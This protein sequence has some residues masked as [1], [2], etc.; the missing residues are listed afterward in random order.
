MWETVIKNVFKSGFKSTSKF[1]ENGN[2]AFA[3]PEKDD[4]S[5][6][7]NSIAANAG[8]DLKSFNLPG[9]E[10]FSSRDAGA[11]PVG[12]PMFKVYRNPSEVKYLPAGYWPEPETAWT[13]PVHYAKDHLKNR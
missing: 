7:G 2:I 10:E 1:L 6:T 9:M 11:I 5:I 8:I 12:K 3:A 4:F 13:L